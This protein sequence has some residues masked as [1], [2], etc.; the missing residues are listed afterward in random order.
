MNESLVSGA[1]IAER[2]IQ[3]GRTLQSRGIDVALTEIIDAER[4]AAGIDVGSRAQLREA[5]R[6]TMVKH[7]RH[8]PAF[9]AAFDRLF[10][11]RPAGERPSGTA[12]SDIDDIAA[13]LVGDEDL[14]A[15]AGDL[16]A[17]YGGFDGELRGERH[18]I[19]RVFKGADLARLMG[20]AR[21]ADPDLSV[22]ELRLRLEELKR[23]IASQVRA[24][25][26]AEED[27]SIGGDV[28][29]IEFL[30][31]TRAELDD[32]RDAVRP[33]ARKLAARLARRR[34]HLRTGRVNVRRT[35]RRSLGTGGVPLH[36]L[37]QRPA[38]HRPELFV[39]CDISGSVAEFSV[40]TL[41]LM[42]ALSAEV[43]RTRSFVFV[44]AIDEVT[45]LLDDTRH[46]IEPWQILR[47][48]N[49]IAEDGHSDYGA[50]LSQFWD[51]TAE[52]ELAPTSTLLITGDA[53]GNYRDASTPVLAAIA[54]RARRVYWLNPEPRAEWDT[55]DS[56]MAAYSRHCSE[57]FE[58][59]NLRQLADCVEMIL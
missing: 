31:A 7:P 6:A 20:D 29:D 1:A 47:N 48:T 59:R 23:E 22:E 10:P 42:A 44:D 25:L 49:V 27:L 34:Q 14:G 43:P 57:V 55:F 5:L 40:F 2:I 4:A 9:E 12:A 26:G 8:Y 32:I 45:G 13:A 38:A 28:E 54:Q 53:R 3:L 33:L 36:V 39:L 37:H 15:V 21:R 51:E 35:I 58:V 56:E 46:G 41:T 18:H 50:V 17:A 24:H 19:R 11:A 30:N 52:R 16:V